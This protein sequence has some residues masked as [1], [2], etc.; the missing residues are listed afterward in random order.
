[1]LLLAEMAGYQLSIAVLES[2]Q[3]EYLLATQNEVAAVAVGAK[4]EK[5]LRESRNQSDLLWV[6]LQ[7]FGALLAQ[8]AIQPARDLAMLA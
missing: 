5:R 2:N 7:L 4:L 6:R 3:I 1:M 8:G